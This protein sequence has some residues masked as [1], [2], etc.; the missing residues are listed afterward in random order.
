MAG[1][2]M[3]GSAPELACRTSRSLLSELGCALQGSQ[4]V[5]FVFY[6]RVLW[7]WR[8]PTRPAGLASRGCPP[9][10]P[11]A[12]PLRSGLCPCSGSTTHTR[13]AAA[14]WTGTKSRGHTHLFSFSPASPLERQQK[15]VNK[16]TCQ[17][18]ARYVDGKR[19][20]AEK[21]GYYGQEQR[22]T[23]RD[24][25]FEINLFP[26]SLAT[27]REAKPIRL[28]ASEHFLCSCLLAA[29]KILS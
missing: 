4:G 26:R 15:Q 1:E 12:L 3:T 27:T 28:E 10:W 20:Q 17:S 25:I 8:A 22:G 9:R 29:H 14:L 21:E 19:E 24:R 7:P 13:P 5:T 11:L 6:S 2:S 16:G 18:H 23:E